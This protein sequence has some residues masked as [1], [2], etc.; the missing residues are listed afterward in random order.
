M[1]KMREE[2]MKVGKMSGAKPQ[3]GGGSSSSS[4]SP[5]CARCG[6]PGKPT[7]QACSVCKNTKYCSKDCQ[8]ND[9]K[10]HKSQCVRAS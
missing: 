10:L 5:Q 7:L 6:G 9:W 3:A 8:K 1:E 4:N 2:V